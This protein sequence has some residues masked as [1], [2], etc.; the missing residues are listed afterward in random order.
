ML[1]IQQIGSADTQGQGCGC[2]GNGKHMDMVRHQAIGPDRYLVL[3]A[4]ALKN[5]Q[6]S[7]PVLII[8]EDIRAV[9]TALGYVVRAVRRNN[10]G[11]SRHALLVRRCP[12][13][14]NTY[15]GKRPHD[16]L[17]SNIEGRF[18]NLFLG[19]DFLG[20]GFLGVLTGSKCFGGF[21]RKGEGAHYYGYWILWSEPQDDMNEHAVCS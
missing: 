6:V 16:T 1:R 4:V 15:Y 18:P 11:Y 21:K 14:V 19:D 12:T 5:V 7:L 13:N 17:S 8:P 2:V 10:S 9:I 3:C 20:S